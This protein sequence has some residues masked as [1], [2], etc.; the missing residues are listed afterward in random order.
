M[1]SSIHPQTHENYLRTE[2]H[3]AWLFR[4]DVLSITE[5]HKLAFHGWLP[6][7]D[8]CSTPFVRLQNENDC[9]CKRLSPFFQDRQECFPSF[10]WTTNKDGERLGSRESHH[11]HLVLTRPVIVLFL[12]VKIRP[13]DTS[14]GS[15]DISLTQQQQLICKKSKKKKRNWWMLLWHAITNL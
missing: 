9:W 1:P 15:R 4:K 6:A 13:R 8:R 5:R 11:A 14:R 2:A 7:L 10:C 3:E 12:C